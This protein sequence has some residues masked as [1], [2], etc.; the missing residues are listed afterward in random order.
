MKTRMLLLICLILLLSQAVG[1]A[2]AVLPDIAAEAGCVLDVQ[3]QK[4]VFEKSSDL[5]MYPASTTK[6]M[7]LI[8]ALEKG[9]LD[10]I[11]TVSPSAASCEGSSLDLKAGDKITLRNLLFGMMLVSGNDA[12][13]AVAEHI[14]G[15][16]ENFVELM[17][18]YAIRIGATRT[19]FSNPHGLPDPG[20][21]YTTAHDLAL[22]TAYAYS[23]PGF[24]EIVSQSSKRIRFADGHIREVFN[25]NR[26]LKYYEGANGVK[27]GFTNEAGYCLVAA[28]NRN[29]AQLIAVVLNSDSRWDDAVDMLDYGFQV[30]N[31]NS[32]LKNKAASVGGRL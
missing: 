23:V 1:A 25:T 32:M 5:I 3:S 15:S 27:T 2:S 9:D 11:V 31:I 4:F 22:I 8:V 12:A 6:I 18:A 26:L 10:S 19:H 28:A 13:E 30:T 24:K 17:N 20:N 21:H 7:T 14:S 29:N 16:A